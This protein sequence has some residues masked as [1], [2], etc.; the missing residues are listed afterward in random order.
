MKNSNEYLLLYG[1]KK[2]E[3]NICIPFMFERTK[4]IPLAWIEKDKET[5]IQIIEDAINSGT[6]QFIFWGLEV[7]WNEIICTIKKQYNGV[8]IKVICNTADSLLYYDYERENFFKLLKLL[9][10]N[11][12]DDVAFLRKG[13]YETYKNLGYNCS[14]ILENI[15][16]DKLKLDYKNDNRELVNIGVY[17]LNYT[18][19]KNIFNQLSVGMFIDNSIVNYN[20]LDARMGDFLTR[21]NINSKADNIKSF[22]AYEIAKVISKNDINLSCDFTDYV[23][24]INLISMECQIPCILGNTSELYDEEL[25]SYL[26]VNSEDNP[27]RIKEKIGYALKNKELIKEKYTKWKAEYNKKSRES[28]LDFINK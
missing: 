20:A 2:P 14:Y 12:V 16:L 7:G 15:S 4:E 10:N 27:L 22:D 13:T 3:D 23:H 9:K 25:N 18:W 28:I 1:N 11:M 6:N 5:I 17:P 26:V 19:D 8:K 24:P 21:M